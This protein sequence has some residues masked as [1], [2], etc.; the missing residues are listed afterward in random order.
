MSQ[1]KHTVNQ[2]IPVEASVSPVYQAVHSTGGFGDAQLL[3]K[4]VSLAALSHT[5]TDNPALGV[6]LG[7][8]CYPT[9]AYNVTLHITGADVFHFDSA[10]ECSPV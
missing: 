7:C 4:V 1:I 9:T 2:H 3:D 8:Y 6:N 10:H 5:V